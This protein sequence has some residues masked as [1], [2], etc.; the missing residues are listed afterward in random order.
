[1]APEQIEGRPVDPRTDV[2]ALGI[3]AYEMVTGRRPFPADNAK[4]LI[5]MHLT[6]DISDPG[7]IVSD[8]P[9]ELREFIIKAG[10]CDPNNRYQDMDQVMAV[11]WPLVRDDRPAPRDAI[12]DKT[13]S[14]SLY[15]TYTD[16]NLAALQ[17]LVDGFKADARALGADVNITH[18]KDH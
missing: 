18:D 8:I 15:L 1:M 10:R 12:T 17:R 2:Y 3:T 7:H 13:K 6:Q 16:D 14:A 4:A 9:D 11:L 5:D